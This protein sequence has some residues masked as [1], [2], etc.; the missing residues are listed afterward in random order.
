MLV[1]KDFSKPKE[2]KSLKKNSSKK[3]VL[4]LTTSIKAGEGTYSQYEKGNIKNWGTLHPGSW[5]RDLK[6]HFGIHTFQSSVPGGLKW[7]PFV[8]IG[9]WIT[10]EV[11]KD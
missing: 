4:I 5:I 9:Q 11:L 1:Y 2:K 6:D 10:Y 7:K 8:A 3:R